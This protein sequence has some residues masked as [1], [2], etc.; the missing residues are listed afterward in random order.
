MVLVAIH[1]SCMD[2]VLKSKSEGLTLGG[3]L[4][5]RVT[6]MKQAGD[7]LENIFFNFHL[8]P[9]FAMLAPPVMVLTALLFLFH[10]AQERAQNDTIVLSWRPI[11]RFGFYSFVVIT[12]VT[13]GVTPYPF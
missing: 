5:F 8:G 11:A 13:V 1:G 9:E 3:W 7:I 12:I 4:L 2:C 10:A 6:S